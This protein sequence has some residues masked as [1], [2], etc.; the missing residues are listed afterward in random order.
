MP[1]PPMAFQ[2]YRDLNATLNPS[3][4]NFFFLSEKVLFHAWENFQRAIT[5]SNT[6]NF[7]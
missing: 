7:S 5:E 2:L 6:I 1:A 3:V 4:Y